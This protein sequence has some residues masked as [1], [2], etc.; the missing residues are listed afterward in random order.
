MIPLKIETLLAGRVVEQDRVEYKKG[1]NPSDT[2]HTICAFANDYSNINGGYIVIGIEAPRGFPMLPPQGVPKEQLDMIQQEIFQYCNIIRPSYIPKMEVVNYRGTDTFLLYLWCSAGD[3]GPYQAPVD[4]YSSKK[5]ENAPDKTMRY[6]IRQA[7]VTTYAKQDEI[8][9]LFEKFNSV[10]FDDRVNRLATIDHIRRGFLEDF[11][12]ESNSSLVSELNRRPMED[13]LISLEVADETDT[14]FSIRN[15]GVL[16]FA[17]KPHKLIPGAQIDLVH[18]HTPEAEGSD[19]FTEKTFTGSI[20]KQVRDALN[21]INVLVIEE[22]VVKIPDRAEADRFF[23]YPYSAL[24]EA[25]VN[26]VFHKSYRDADP[27]EIRIYVDCIMILNYPGPEKWIDMGKFAEGKI[28]SRRYRNRRI[29]EF[30]K[31]INLSE[32]QSTGI[33]KIIRALEQNGSPPPEF[34]TVDE[35]VYLITTIRKREGFDSRF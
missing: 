1:W 2:I 11:L 34:E 23:N 33:T 24:E 3:S 32:K 9:E 22:K 7:S 15:I 20:Q 6:W 16:M 31:E 17:D 19:N 5:T 29:G 26:A 4:V 14:D 27:V 35:R 8:A 28:R 12:R 30:F 25:L 21:Y 18:F 13:I 10:P